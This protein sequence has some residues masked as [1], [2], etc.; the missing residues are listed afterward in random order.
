MYDD[1]EDEKGHSGYG[2]TVSAG[3]DFRQ[4]KGKESAVLK[5]SKCWITAIGIICIL[6]GIFIVVCALYSKY[7][8]ANFALLEKMLPHGTIWCLLAFGV[9]LSIC[10]IVL[11][12]A[13]CNYKRCICK[14]VLLIFSIILMV[15]CVAEILS[16]GVFIYF[17]NKSQSPTDNALAAEIFHL[18]DVAVNATYHECCPYT[19]NYTLVQEVCKW[20][21]ASATVQEECRKSGYSGHSTSLNIYN[22]VCHKGAKWY[23]VYLAKFFAEKFLWVGGLT[24]ALAIP[25]LIAL[26]CSCVLLCKKHKGLDNN[27]YHDTDFDSAHMN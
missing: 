11:I 20:P 13:A 12:A 7:A 10:A 21:D 23:G 5:C 14:V 22:C 16:G 17:L 25:S 3:K 1:M 18:R 2:S 27:L 8:Y 4:H 19:G 15:L 26:V 24:I 6:L 9:A